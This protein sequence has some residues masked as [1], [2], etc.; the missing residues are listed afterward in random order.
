[1]NDNLVS[2][3][4]EEFKDYGKYKGILMTD[5]DNYIPVS[6]AKIIVRK[7]VEGIRYDWD[8]EK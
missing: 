3:I 5:A 6:A 8:D 7:N 2:N 4:I 1:M